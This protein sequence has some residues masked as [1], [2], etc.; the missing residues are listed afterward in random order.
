MGCPGAINSRP[1][2][3]WPTMAANWLLTSWAMPPVRVPTV[4][5]RWLCW[6]FNWSSTS[7]SKALPARCRASLRVPI[8]RMSVGMETGTEP[9]PR[10]WA[11]SERRSRGL[12][13]DGPC[14]RPARSREGSQNPRAQDHERHPAPPAAIVLIWHRQAEKPLHPLNALEGLDDAGVTAI[15]GVAVGIA[16]LGAEGNPSAL[17]TPGTGA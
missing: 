6:S 9:V 11:A 5:R 17:A 4:S 10:A 13:S 12:K 14:G 1:R 2:L 3:I 16:W 8:S 15:P 7:F